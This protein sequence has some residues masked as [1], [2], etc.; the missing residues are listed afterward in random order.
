M[1]LP[2]AEVIGDPVA[3]SKS[4][5]IHGFWLEKLGLDGEYHKTHVTT[6]GLADFFASRKDD[7]NWRG[8]NVTAPHKQA[9]LEFVT[10]RGRVGDSIGAMNTI[11]RE[12]DGTL[13]GT[14]TDAAGFFG[15]ISDLDLIDK[16][17]VV[18]GAGG[19]A[20][21][22]LFALSRCA[23]G[24]V[25]VMNRRP[26][27]AAA[28]LAKF[29][30]KGN[31]VGLDAP[32]PPAA[33]IV[34]ASTLGMVGA[35]PF[36]PDLSAQRDDCVVYDIV[37]SPLQTGLLAAAEDQGLET[38]DG[39]EMLVGQAAVAFELFFDAEPPRQHDDELRALLLR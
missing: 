38:I 35:P 6:E 37:Y 26:L 36:E 1:T 19:A 12:P 7:A 24:N 2:Y 33:L 4:P 16:K 10:D 28:L 14:N 32:L 31:V 11:I 25:T 23:V 8:C 5:I 22:V 27:P 20:R 34:N 21:A 29:G 15:P 3:Q 17:V 13:I 30:L 39:L 9:V 18:I